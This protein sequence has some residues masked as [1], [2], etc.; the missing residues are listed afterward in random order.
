MHGVNRTSD[1]GRAERRRSH[2]VPS[3]RGAVHPLFGHLPIWT[4]LGYL[5]PYCNLAVIMAQGQKAPVSPSGGP[6]GMVL[7][8]GGARGAYQVG[9]LNWI[10]RRYPDLEVPILT[11]VSAGAVNTAC[12]ASHPA[13]FGPSVEL[14]RQ[15]WCDLTV[16]RVYRVDAS[17][18]ANTAVRWGF[19]LLSGGSQ[20]PRVRG[21]LD[22]S[23]LRRYLHAVLEDD[24]GVLTGIG[25]NI[26]QGKLRAVALVTT[27]YSTNQT[28]VFVQGSEIQPWTRPQRRA[29]QTQL[30]IEHIM[31]S[32]ALPL[33]FPAIKVGGEWFG[34]GGIRLAAPLSPVLHL[35]AN[36]ILAIST[37]YDK[38]KAETEVPTVDGYP[39]PAQVLGSLLNAVFLDL[40]DQDAVRL[41]SMN[42][43]LAELRPGHRA[44]MRIVDL[45]VMRPSRDLGKLAADF[46]PQMP[47]A[48]RFM[49]RGLGTRE[50]KSPDVLSLLMFQQDYIRRLME[51]GERDAAARADELDAFLSPLVPET[52]ASS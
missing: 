12:I 15:L 35:G 47:K 32:T 25:R 52:A 26:D 37:R 23:P 36:R 8:G 29:V 22:T 2:D 10:A 44:G 50:Q 20:T 4:P 46:E 42:R 48:F 18:M 3:P 14:L 24:G 5:G 1:R 16:G 19:R 34:D 11:G 13:G 17:A 9:V 40:I 7:T 51:I 21:F 27:S 6:L 31:A 49:T 28:V 45:L 33:F 43:L 38:S 30:T 41:Q 39:P